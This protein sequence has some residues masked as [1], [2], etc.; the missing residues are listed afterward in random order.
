MAVLGTLALTALRNAQ[1]AKSAAAPA[2]L[3]AVEVEAVTSPAAEK[4]L[5]TAMISAAKS[6]GQI[7]QAEMQKIIGKISADSVTPE[8]K[9]FVLEQMA[10]PIDIPGLAAQVHGQPQAAQVYAASLMTIAADTPAEQAYLRELAA[11]LDLDPAAVDQ[12]H[13]MTGAGALQA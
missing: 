7:D 1:A 9:Q 12:L 3:D 6:D 5:V 13:Q 4:L 10:A 8:E 11:A 2:E